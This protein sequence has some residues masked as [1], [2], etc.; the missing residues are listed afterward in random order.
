MSDT[1]TEAAQ[2]PARR[3]AAS[4]RRGLDKRGLDQRRRLVRVQRDQGGGRYWLIQA[5]VGGS[6]DIDAYPAS[7]PW[8]PFD[9][10]AGRRL[11]RDPSIG[12]DDAHDFRIMYEA[13]AEPDLSPA[14]RW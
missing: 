3:P 5:G 1:D 4:R 11:Y 2:A 12:L 6:P 10:T 14:T 7:T 8:G 13:R 9:F